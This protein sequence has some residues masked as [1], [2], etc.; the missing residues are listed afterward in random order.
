MTEAPT[1]GFEPILQPRATGGLAAR[2]RDLLRRHSRAGQRPIGPRQTSSE[3]IW[4]PFSP[5][6]MRIEVRR[7]L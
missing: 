4:R 5:E 7:R 1:T 3:E 6:V 2:I